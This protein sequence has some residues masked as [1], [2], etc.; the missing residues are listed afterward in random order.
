MPGWVKVDTADRDPTERVDYWRQSVCNEFVPLSV[1]PTGN[2]LQGR[3]LGR[4]IAE[5]RLRRIQ[6]TTHTF[7][8]RLRDIRTSDPEVLSLLRQDHGRA[9]LHQDGRTATLSPGDVVVYDSSRKFEVTTSKEFQFTISLLPKRLLP[10]PERRIKETTARTFPG[11]DAVPAATAAFL[12]SMVRST[13]EP[14][15]AQQLALQHALV[16]MYV[17]LISDS[18]TSG[19]PPTVHLTMAKSFIARNL[20]NPQLGTADIAAACNISVSYL[21]R[22]FANDAETVAGFL[23][24]QRLTAAYRDLASPA[25]DQP[26][27]IVA[28]RWG[29][30]DPAHFNRTFKKRFGIT[31]GE[32]RRTARDCGAAQ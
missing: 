16:S 12:T 14:A 23:R 27:A 13:P 30:S 18:E 22:I 26:V 20:G 11:T 2:A 3:V 19:S 32:C 10:V 4:H 15:P 29:F 6:A 28:Q 8:R 17:A 5:T 25:I 7:T 24:E 1:E 9:T 31:P 21:H